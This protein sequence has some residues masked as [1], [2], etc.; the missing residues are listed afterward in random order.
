[1][2]DCNGVSDMSVEMSSSSQQSNSSDD[3]YKVSDNSDMQH[4]T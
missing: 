4:G 1:V 3:E 2:V